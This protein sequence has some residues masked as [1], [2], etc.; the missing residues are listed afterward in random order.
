LLNGYNDP[1][2]KNT[3][4]SLLPEEVQGEMYRMFN[5]QNK[6]ITQ[7]TLGEIHQTCIVALDKLYN[8]Q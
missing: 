6:E 1:S 5:M 4:V 8:Q 7:M 3:Y 2:L